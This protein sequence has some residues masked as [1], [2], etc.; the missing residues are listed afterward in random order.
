MRRD[1]D[2]VLNDPRLKNDDTDDDE[3][4][5]EEEGKREHDEEGFELD[6]LD[7]E[8]PAPASNNQPDEDEI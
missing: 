5:D 3:Q 6:E 1:V 7:D 2:Q 4:E 8:S